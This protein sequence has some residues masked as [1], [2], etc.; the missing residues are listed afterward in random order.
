LR[1]LGDGATLSPEKEGG[2]EEAMKMKRTI[3]ETMREEPRVACARA[4]FPFRDGEC[5]KGA[6]LA[7]LLGRFMMG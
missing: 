4:L 7:D 5:G 6:N 3:D 2:D 1:G